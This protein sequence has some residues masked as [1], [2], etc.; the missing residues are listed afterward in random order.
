MVPLVS[1]FISFI[2]LSQCDKKGI[3]TNPSAPINPEATTTD[4]RLNNFDWRNLLYNINS[5]NTPS[6]IDAPFNQANNTLVNHFLNNRD[7][8][9]DDGWELIKHDLGFN[10]DGSPR[11]AV[12]TIFLVLYNKYRGTLRVFLQGNRN[13]AYNGA[14][15]TVYFLSGQKQSSILNNASKIWALD[16]Y[17]QDSL[18]SVSPYNND[19]GRWFYADF[20]MSY[21]PCTCF[22][23][24]TLAVKTFL[25]SK[26]NIQLSGSLVGTITPANLT[27]ISNNAG[28]VADNK[29]SFDAKGL[30]N[31]AKKAI[32]TY[33]DFSSFASD[34]FKAIENEGKTNLQI[35]AEELIRKNSIDKLQDAIKKS[36]FL[37]AGLKVAPFIG[38]AVDLV[39]F[40]VGGGKSAPQEVTITP[41][42][43]NATLNL[44]GTLTST[45]E[46]N[47]ITFYTPGSK[48]A[49][50]KNVADYPKYNE[51]LGV[52]SL[53][54]TPKA[55]TKD[56]IFEDYGDSFFCQSKFFQ[57]TSNIQYVINPAAGY[58]TDNVEILAN[59]VFKKGGVSVSETGYLP[60][61]VINNFSGRIRRCALYGGVTSFYD[62]VY[63]KLLVNLTRLDSDPTKQNTLFVYTYQVEMI[64]DPSFTGWSSNIF[65]MEQ[66]LDQEFTGVFQNA[67][68]NGWRSS[69]LFAQSTLLPNTSLTAGADF[70]NGPTFIPPVSATDVTTFCSTTY[71]NEPLRNFRL[72]A[73]NA[74]KNEDS[75]IPEAF[76]SAFP[77]PTTSKVSFRYDIEEPSQVRLN[78]IS[79]TGSVVATPVDAYQEAGAYEMSYDASNL[80]A[81]VYVYTLETNKGKETKRLV[82]IK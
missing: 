69:A 70:L 7:N 72:A 21:D 22:Y 15:I 5:S 19:Q 18:K 31:T 78:L 75:K 53:L 17:S 30:F 48:N 10:Y 6:P 57:M 58:R 61:S 49:Q 37:K 2:G 73:E 41:M 14:E 29:H 63:L 34:Q 43:I 79:T 28:T 12:G 47:A 74:P 59:L 65:P 62:E 35:K 1:L 82:I 64:N 11:V 76:L 27:S 52:F 55:F 16:K 46:Y 40:F 81:G 44:K 66:K 25:I 39:D 24:S 9:P 36:D 68:L 56:D 80:P 60:I 50:L 45:F 54:R 51:V 20:Y 33:N 26:S 8:S 71:Q 32:K 42:A 38:A 77:N 13:P 4:G 23:E 3:T 67:S